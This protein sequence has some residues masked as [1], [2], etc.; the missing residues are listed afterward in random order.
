MVEQD[1]A[2]SAIL[3]VPAVKTDGVER[4]NNDRLGAECMSGL[5]SCKETKPRQE[6]VGP[7]RQ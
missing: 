3:V 1:K 2:V 5:L 7:E 6:V 4:E